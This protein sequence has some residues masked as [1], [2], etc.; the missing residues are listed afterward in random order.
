MAQYGTTRVQS[1]KSQG[2]Q[3]YNDKIYDHILRKK[4]HPFGV[5]ILGF[6]EPLKFQAEQSTY[7]SQMT[8]LN[9]IQHLSWDLP[10]FLTLLS[11]AQ[12]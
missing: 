1:V 7:V 8:V 6:P 12:L 5:L 10:K 4:K 11:C 9:I 2:L 3:T